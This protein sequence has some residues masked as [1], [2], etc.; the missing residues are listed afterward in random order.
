MENKG[1]YFLG[2]HLDHNC[3]GS[4]CPVWYP[5]DVDLNKIKHFEIWTC[6]YCHE[7]APEHLILQWKLLNE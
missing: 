2:R 6:I 5:S 7:K 4:M 3:R 1:F